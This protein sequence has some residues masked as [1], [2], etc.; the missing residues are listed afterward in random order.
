MGLKD[1]VG[2]LKALW[3]GGV[4]YPQDFR[5]GE[6][7]ESKRSQY[8]RA[9]NLLR[10][11]QLD[12]LDADISAVYSANNA[13]LYRAQKMTFNIIGRVVDK[14]A[15]LYKQ[16]P[17][18]KGPD[19]FA[20]LFTEDLT[21]VLRQADRVSEVCG[22]AWVGV[23]WDDQTKRLR[24]VCLPPDQVEPVWNGDALEAL[25]IYSRAIKEN[26]TKREEVILRTEWTPTSYRIYE[27]GEDK[28]AE[29][30][31]EASGF[32][33]YGVIPYV[34][35][36]PETPLTGEP[37]GVIRES[38]IQCQRTLN[39][40]LTELMV[41]M[42]LQAG[43]QPVY[44]GSTP[45]KDLAVGVGNLVFLE[46]GLSGETPD[47]FFASPSAN[48][49]GCWETLQNLLQYLA[50][51]HGLSGQW[52][53]DTKAP[54]GVALQVNNADLEEYREAKQQ[55]HKAFWSNLVAVA[56]AVAGYSGGPTADP[57]EVTVLFASPKVYE[58]PMAVAQQWQLE[59]GALVRSRAEWAL[60]TH[61][62]L[63]KEADPLAAAKALVDANATA[64]RAVRAI[65][66][67]QAPGPAAFTSDAL[68]GMKNG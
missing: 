41:L 50:F 51:T 52:V 54:S 60:A 23:D 65:A 11:R 45:P 3:A 18:V 12:T 32:P 28:T 31:P 13:R 62:E 66:M 63:R 53:I 9:I 59:V 40:K 39:I 48:I 61:P 30:A 4:W 5:G 17:E 10:G 36:Y 14:L 7:W 49:E 43:S 37:D 68:R 19:A 6:T 20:A 1:F 33:G 57:S 44:R 16:P 67:P 35:M 24:L 55:V 34:P 2:G 29:W 56:S 22:I 38:L 42:S 58:D 26:G 8:L 64:E 27:D 47:F 15:M 25:S 21:P 46:S